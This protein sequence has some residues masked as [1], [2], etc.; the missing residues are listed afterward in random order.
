MAMYG[1]KGLNSIFRG[2][3]PGLPALKEGED[4]DVGSNVLDNVLTRKLDLQGKGSTLKAKFNTKTNLPDS[5]IFKTLN[6]SG[7]KKSFNFDQYLKFGGNSGFNID[8]YLRTGTKSN[9]EKDVWAKLRLNTNARPDRFSRNLVVSPGNEDIVPDTQDVIAQAQNID[10]DQ[11]QDNNMELKQRAID[12]GQKTADVIDV[13]LQA[14]N[15][16]IAQPALKVGKKIFEKGKERY[17]EYKHEKDREEGMSKLIKIKQREAKRKVLTDPVF[18]RELEHK[19]L[20]YNLELARDKKR[21]ELGLGGMSNG[22]KVTIGSGKKKQTLMI[23]GGTG[24]YGQIQQNGP[25]GSLLPK[26]AQADWRTYFSQNAPGSEASI[27]TAIRGGGLVNRENN[28]L[29]MT[30]VGGN[31]EAGLSRGGGSQQLL[32]TIQS[33]QQFS[34]PGNLSGAD[35]IRWIT[36]SKEQREQMLQMLQQQPVQT[37]TPQPVQQSY[38]VGPQPVSKPVPQGGEYSPYSK[39]PVTYIRG[40]YRKRQ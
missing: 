15:K 24:G 23:S 7:S 40:P 9:Q 1:M 25:F 35:K 28:L 39:K 38:D 36:A 4:D 29:Q 8:Q 17:E 27:M 22:Q 6:I 11:E 21:Q 3:V 30:R 26:T 19:R 18:L 12:L 2:R 33:N 14:G 34:F 20:L 16:Y 13:G 31:V 10:M 5:Q 32:S 37:F